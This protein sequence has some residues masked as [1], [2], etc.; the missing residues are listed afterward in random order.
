MLMTNGSLLKVKRIAYCRML[1]L[2]H[3]AI[4]LTCIKVVPD[5][6][7]YIQKVTIF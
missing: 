7:A 5:L 3:S 4:L 6:P 2:A 1:Q